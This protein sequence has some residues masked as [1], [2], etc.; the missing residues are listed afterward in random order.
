MKFTIFLFALASNGLNKVLLSSENSE[1]G[2]IPQLR[3]KSFSKLEPKVRIGQFINVLYKGKWNSSK[4]SQNGFVN[5]KSGSIIIVFAQTFDPSKLS[6]EFIFNEGYYIEDRYMAAL[7]DI[8]L[9][10]ESQTVISGKADKTDIYK[11]EHIF[12]NQGQDLCNLKTEVLLYNSHGT[13]QSITVGSISDLIIKGNISSDN[14]ELNVDFTVSALQIEIIGIVM[15]TIIQTLAAFIGFYPFYKALKTNNFSEINTLSSTAFLLNIAIDLAIL[16]MN[17]TFS[18]RV[19]PEYFEFLALLTMFMF[20]TVIFKI[21]TYI[22][23]FEKNIINL[24]RSTGEFSRIKFN[25]FIKFIIIC[26]A[27]VGFSDFLIVYY[28]WFILLSVYPIFQIAYNSR[29]NLRSQC[30]KLDL[31]AALIIPQFLFPLSIRC[32]N[33]HFFQLRQDYNFGVTLVTILIAQLMVMYLQKLLG[34]AFFLPK[35]FI[36]EYFEYIKKLKDLEDPENHNCPICFACLNELPENDTQITK[37]LLPYQFMETP[38]HHKYHESCLK[39]W[40]EQK[41]ICPCCRASIPPY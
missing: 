39:A 41:L 1:N 36:K 3:T 15:F 7:F 37:K 10:D 19:I 11:V 8:T 28:K 22:T 21:R 13:P 9:S 30:F 32:L 20:T 40:M 24:D 26:F 33:L 18:I 2:K 34:P 17:L 12:G 27:A 23:L 38:C 25:F 4:G 5:A 14:C 16:S 35:I 31:H 6:I 29:H